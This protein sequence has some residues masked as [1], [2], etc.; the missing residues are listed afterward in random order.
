MDR[1]PHFTTPSPVD[2]IPPAT[3][4]GSALQHAIAVAQFRGHGCIRC[5]V[6]QD[7]YVDSSIRSENIDRLRKHI[8]DED[9]GNDTERHLTI[10]AAESEIGDVTP[11]RRD[12]GAW[13]GRELGRP[14]DVCA[15]VQTP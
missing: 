11:K 8:L 3:G 2:K 4:S 9:I 10:D 13:R 12:I 6:Y 1:P 7:S 15:P 14:H 5:S